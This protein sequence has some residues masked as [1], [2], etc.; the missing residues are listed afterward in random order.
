MSQYHFLDESG[1]PGLNDSS[2]SSRHFVIAIIQLPN[3]DLLPE[4]AN[5]RRL[6][7]LP[8]LFEFKYYSAKSH[9]KIAFFQAVSSMPF[10]VRSVILDKL[11]LPVQFVG[12]NG[13]EITVELISGLVLR[14]SVLD[15]AND[16]LVIDGATVPLI[17]DLRVRIS[18]ECR[19]IGRVR[20]F[21]KITPGD[22]NREDGVQLADMIA[23]AI[24]DYKL[25]N[26]QQHYHS[27]A[28][29]VVDLWDK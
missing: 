22:S 15:I 12:M 29:K 18:V 20:P 8:P 11:A 9:Q 1:D 6:L 24:R 4:L 17:R 23:G 28:S 25:N 10:R 21:R 3:S 26:E 16:V 19:R 27:F 14:A 5:V 13:P 7:H 2:S